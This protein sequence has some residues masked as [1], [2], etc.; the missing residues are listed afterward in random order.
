MPNGQPVTPAAVT[1]DIVELVRAES[2][3]TDLGPALRVQVAGHVPGRNPH[4]AQQ[5]QRQVREVLAYA[6]AFPQ[7]IQS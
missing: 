2:G 7:R 3:V 1:Q 4:A 5:D 6:F